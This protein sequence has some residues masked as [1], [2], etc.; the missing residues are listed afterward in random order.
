MS[1]VIFGT[2]ITGTPQEMMQETLDIFFKGIAVCN[3]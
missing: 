2:R 1:P 3:Q